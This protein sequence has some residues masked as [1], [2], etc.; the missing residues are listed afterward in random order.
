MLDFFK[1]SPAYE[2]MT[3]D[4]RKEGFKQGFEQG[5]AQGHQ[6]GI[7]QGRQEAAEIFRQVIIALAAKR[8]PKLERLA[9]KQVRAT[10]DIELLQ[11]AMIHI[12]LA[13]DSIEAG[14]VLL[15]LDKEE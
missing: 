1:D 13:P 8:F 15:D 10:D 5:L 7:K 4:T 2:W 14:I 12:G 6:E 3:E 9:K 11:N